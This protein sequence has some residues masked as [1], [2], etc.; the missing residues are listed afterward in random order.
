MCANDKLAAVIWRAIPA[1]AGVAE[2]KTTQQIR[3]IVDVLRPNKRID[4]RTRPPQ[5]YI[6]CY[7]RQDLPDARSVILT[8]TALLVFWGRDG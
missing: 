1:R 3:P 5:N 2:R 8:E 7:T 6:F 4:A